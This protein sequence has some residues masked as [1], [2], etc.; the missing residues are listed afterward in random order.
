MQCTVVI[1]RTELRAA[2]RAEKADIEQTQ[3]VVPFITC[4]MSMTMTMTMTHPNEVSTRVNLALRTR[5][6]GVVTPTSKK[7]LMRVKC[8]FV[9][10]SAS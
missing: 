6:G 9:K 1:L 8:P 2:L 3:K 10:M 5:T 7:L 4:E